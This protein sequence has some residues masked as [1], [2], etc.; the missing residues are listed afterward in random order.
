MTSVLIGT[1]RKLFE[2]RAYAPRSRQ[3]WLGAAASTAALLLGLAP[4]LAL[5]DFEI[6]VVEKPTVEPPAPEEGKDPE[7]FKDEFVLHTDD[8]KVNFTVEIKHNEG[9]TKEGKAQK[10]TDAINVAVQA[11]Y[12]NKRVLATRDGTKV[13]FDGFYRTAKGFFLNATKLEA[14]TNPSKEKDT[15]K[16][17]KKVENVQASVRL[18]GTASGLAAGGGP[19]SFEVALG[20]TSDQFG[21][22]S[23][24]SLISS[25]D[26]DSLTPDSILTHLF[27]DLSS[28]LPG[29]LQ[30]DLSLDLAGGSISF[31]SSEL[32]TSAS[33]LAFT[34]DATSSLLGSLE[35][36]PVPEPSALALMA[37]GG[38]GWLVASRHR[39][40]KRGDRVSREQ[41]GDQAVRA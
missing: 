34:S 30:S 33:I 16:F 7:V 4:S 38:L 24:T 19:S 21:D 39:R 20:L 14:L 18:D 25:S 41:C 17:G 23:V 36:R 6:N 37:I 28:Q 13:K 1:F 32:F 8:G 11:K 12:N 3:R 10:I 27:D 29:G 35:V 15:Y 5:A 26:L 2:I 31:T 40:S 9:L 22:I